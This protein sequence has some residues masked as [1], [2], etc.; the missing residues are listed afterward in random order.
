MEPKRDSAE[1]SIHRLIAGYRP[2]AGIHDEMLGANGQPRALW[3]GLIASLD[4]MPA[5]ER[6]ERFARS[7]QYLRDAG[8]A[9][10]R[11]RKRFCRRAFMA[12]RRL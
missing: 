8:A 10:G 3:A 1:R 2:I 6:F 11:F 4:A 12:S 7:D 5:R 9:R